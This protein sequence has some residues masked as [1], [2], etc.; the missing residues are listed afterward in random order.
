M[1]GRPPPG[2]TVIG[3][4]FLVPPPQPPQVPFYKVSSD[5]AHMQATY[6]VGGTTWHWD[7]HAE[8]Q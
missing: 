3:P 2:G 7:L 8:S 5:G 6:I 1:P 4:W